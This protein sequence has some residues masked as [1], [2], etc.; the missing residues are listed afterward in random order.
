MERVYEG[1]LEFT[2]VL[3]PVNEHGRMAFFTYSLPSRFLSDRA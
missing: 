1:G 2:W 3:H